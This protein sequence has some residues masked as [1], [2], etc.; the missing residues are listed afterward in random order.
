MCTGRYLLMKVETIV[1]ADLS[2]IG[3]A[4]GHPVKWSIIVWMCLF[5]DVD[6]SHSVTRSI[7]ICWMVCQELP[8]SEEGNFEFWPFLCDIVCS[9]LYI[10]ECL[11]SFPS[12]SIDALSSS[13]CRYFPEVLTCHGLPLE[14]CTSKIWVWLEQETFDLNLWSVS[15]GVCWHGWSVLFHVEVFPLDKH[16]EI[17]LQKGLVFCMW[18]RASNLSAV[19]DLGVWFGTGETPGVILGCA[20]EVSSGRCCGVWLLVLKAGPSVFETNS[21]LIGAEVV[22]GSSTK[23]ERQSAALFLAPDIHS[24]VML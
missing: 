19:R 16:L 22:L 3:N 10:S 1:S 9:W 20:V 24:N 12:N 11:C 23:H 15:I 2:S 21:M 13:R 6:V 18:R 8:S 4:S 7:A 5:P 17:C 14:L